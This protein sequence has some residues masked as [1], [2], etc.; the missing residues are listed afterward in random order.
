MPLRALPPQGSASANFATWAV[1][2][3][4][5]RVVPRRWGEQAY[6]LSGTV[7]SRSPTPCDPPR[8]PERLGKSPETG[9][10]PSFRGN[11]WRGI[12]VQCTVYWHRAARAVRRAQL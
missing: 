12:G 6:A 10:F 11:A 8:A 9:E 1:T 4:A 7:S 2:L 3:G 5:A